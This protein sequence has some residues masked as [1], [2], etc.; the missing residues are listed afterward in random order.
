M[1][2]PEQ[3]KIYT[4]VYYLCDCYHIQYP[5]KSR[6]YHAPN[7]TYQTAIL[8]SSICC[9]LSFGSENT[10]NLEIMCETRCNGSVRRLY[11][12]HHLNKWGVVSAEYTSRVPARAQN[13]IH[14]RITIKIS[15]KYN[16]RH[17]FLKKKKMEN[18]MTYAAMNALLYKQKLMTQ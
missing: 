7:K 15:T 3:N 12:A 13:R 9:V 2:N 1:C 5:V 16:W 17:W 4:I 11:N 10:T 8:V 14:H 18:I 6:N